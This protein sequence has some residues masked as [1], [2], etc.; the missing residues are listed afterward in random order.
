MNEYDEEC[1]LTFLKNN[2]RLFDEPG[3][4]DNGRGRGFSGR[5]LWRS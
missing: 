5:L 1:L 4:R 3:G 2:R